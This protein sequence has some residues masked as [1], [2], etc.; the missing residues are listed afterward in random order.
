MPGLARSGRKLR[1]PCIIRLA[2]RSA[3]EVGERNLPTGFQRALAAGEELLLLLHDVERLA[4]ENAVVRRRL[5]LEVGHG[6]VLHLGLLG[7][8]LDR[9]FLAARGENGVR[10]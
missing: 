10:L 3:D 1:K 6:A 8:L 4:R 7:A 9:Q 5:G 2:T